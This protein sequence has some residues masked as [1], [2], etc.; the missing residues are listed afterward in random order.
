MDALRALLRELDGCLCVVGAALS[1]CLRVH[2]A[3][4][5]NDWFCIEAAR[6]GALVEAMLAVVVAH[7]ADAELQLV[8]WAVISGQLECAPESETGAAA[9]ACRRGALPAGMRALQVHRSNDALQR[10]VCVALCLIITHC[11]ESVASQLG[12]LGAVEAAAASLRQHGAVFDTVIRAT[13]LLFKLTQHH[14]NCARALRADV[15]EA[16]AAAMR[17]HVADIH[18]AFLGYGALSNLCPYD[19]GTLVPRFAASNIVGLAIS[20]LRRLAAEEANRRSSACLLL[21]NLCVREDMARAIVAFGGIPAILT[22]MRVPPVNGFL[23]DRGIAVFCKICL[24]APDLSSS[25]VAAGVV[26]GVVAVMMMEPRE[27]CSDVMLFGYDALARLTAADV[28]A[29]QRAIKAGALRLPPPGDTESREIRDM[30]FQRLNDAVAAADA[31]A[32]SFMAEL[33]AEEAADKAGGSAASNK[34]KKSKAKKAAGGAGGV[35]GAAEGA[36]PAA[37]PPAALAARG[38]EGAAAA[39]DDEQP[40]LPLPAAAP[41]AAP[42]AAAERRRRRA[43]TKASRRSGGHGA[44]GSA[45]AAAASS[46]DD[47]APEDAAAGSGMAAA[48]TEEEEAQPAAASEHPMESMFPWLRMSANAAPPAS[49]L[50]PPPLPLPPLPRAPWDAAPPAPSA[51]QA[52]LAAMIAQLA[53]QKAAMAAQATALAAKDAAFA[54]LKAEA[55]AAPK[56]SICLDATPCVVLLPCRHQPLCA[57]PACAAMLGVPPLCPLC[58]EPVADTMHTFV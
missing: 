44:S 24:H 15:L 17:M 57:A 58:R 51:E 55:D 26:E 6:D 27:S 12:D 30:L 3:V 45:E 54:K 48:T 18:L 42:S 46:D 49:P 13:A 7:P 9:A 38:A 11:D 31:K 10:H 35:A 28:S 23:H 39:D 56:C 25:L 41:P 21:A 22:A 16:V 34:K 20:G 47:A 2:A 19:D 52:Q 33:L 4:T 50:P 53:E 29:T 40:A 8:A 37:V 14:E 43:A 5:V 32:D 1:C 36:Q